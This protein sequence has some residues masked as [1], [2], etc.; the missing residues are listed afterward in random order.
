M[1]EKP[2]SLNPDTYENYYISIIGFLGLRFYYQ[3]LNIFKTC[4]WLL[5][6]NIL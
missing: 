5:F 2:D 6:I 3:E 1:T 4:I